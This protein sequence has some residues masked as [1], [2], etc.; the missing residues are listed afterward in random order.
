MRSF[1][2]VV[3]ILALIGPMAAT[4]T[5]EDKF[6]GAIWQMRVKNEKGEW[7][8]VAKF[9]ATKDGKVYFEGK[10]IGTH[11]SVNANEVTMEWTEKG[12]R[13]NGKY[14]L[15]RVRKDGAWWAGTLTRAN[16]GVEVPIRLGL[17]GD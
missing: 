11:K 6:V 3:C 9:R 14:K 2:L 15:L 4:A 17:I 7:I 16:D 1:P 10:Q 12:P 13:L 8:D 5:V